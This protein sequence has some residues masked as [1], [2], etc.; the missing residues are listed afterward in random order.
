MA[1]V[2]LVQDNSIQCVSLEDVLH[3][4]PT[5]RDMD[6]FVNH[7]ETTC[8]SHGVVVDIFLDSTVMCNCL[9]GVN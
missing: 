5:E 8:M 2:K 9:M 4:T 6:V 3:V 1:T 7:P